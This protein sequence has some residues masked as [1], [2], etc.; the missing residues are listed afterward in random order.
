MIE[1]TARTTVLNDMYTKDEI[2]DGITKKITFNKT[3]K[4]NK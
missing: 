4:T 1:M 3:R 2:L